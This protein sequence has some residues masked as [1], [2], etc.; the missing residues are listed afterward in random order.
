MDKYIYINESSI[1]KELCNIIVEKY[2]NQTTGIREGIVM[3]GLNKNIKISLDYDI[4]NNSEWSVIHKCLETELNYNMSKYFKNL[5]VD[6]INCN[7]CQNTTS[8]YR[9][10]DEENIFNTGFMIKKYIK[11]MGRYV[12]HNDYAVTSKATRIL[13]FIWY[14]NDVCEGGET[15][16]LSGKYKIQPKAGK[17]LLFPAS[18]MFPHCG[19][20]PLSC[21]K[22][23]ITGWMWDNGYHEVYNN[24]NK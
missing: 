4:E 9:I 20:I 3:G 21:D 6:Y 8:T 15:E 24:K 7:D 19:K 18:W 16:F 5:N 13:T 10:I 14:L 11:N 2:N 22:Y 17:F 1:S 23:I 12:Y